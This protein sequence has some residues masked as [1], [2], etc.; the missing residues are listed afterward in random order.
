M[1]ALNT[2]W[3]ESPLMDR[4]L[5]A[6][7]LG[8]LTFAGGWL[9]SAQ[10]APPLP[11]L[12][13]DTTSK[14]KVSA[15]APN[16]STRVMVHVAGAV[17]HPGVYTLSSSAR[18]NDALRAA[19]G[20][21]ADADPNHLNL[22]AHLQDGE[23]VKIPTKAE[24]TATAQIALPSHDLLQQSSTAVSDESTSSNRKALP[25][26]PINVNTA[27]ATELESLPGVGP[28]LATR[29]VAYRNQHGRLQSLRDLDAVKGFGPRKLQKIQPYVTF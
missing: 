23:Q 16:T 19:G 29:I 13:T 18:I 8:V 27:S 7:C 26:Q 5:T 28:A 12:L 14:N 11:P 24:S 2:F 20:A 1:R 9:W 22:A 17:R 6:T 21:L 3:H 4:L 25:T 10:Q 15:L